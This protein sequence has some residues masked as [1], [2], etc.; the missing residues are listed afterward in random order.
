MKKFKLTKLSKYLVGGISLSVLV[1]LLSLVDF[2]LEK[3]KKDE[4]DFEYVDK[5][6]VDEQLP[7][8]E[9]TD[10]IIK[11]YLNENVKV[12][13]NY[14][15]YQGTEEEQENSIL[16]YEATYMPNY[17]IAYGG[18]ED[19]EVISILDGTVI[20]IKEDDLLGIIVEVKHENDLISVYQ[21]IKDVTVKENQV[22]KQGEV[23]GKGGISNINKSLGNHLLFELI[24]KGKIVNPEEYYNKDVNQL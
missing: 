4:V 22:V 14:Y 21:S 3:E 17:A 16:Y 10:T 12:V 15:N 18:V 5:V 19:F 7:V 9:S 2:S 8:I 1:A 20:S 11:P 13:K 6:V 23:L 24:L